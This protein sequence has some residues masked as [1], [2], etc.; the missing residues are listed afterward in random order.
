[1]RIIL[2]HCCKTLPRSS[3]YYSCETFKVIKY[4]LSIFLLYHIILSKQ[5]KW[6]FD[7]ESKTYL[8]NSDTAEFFSNKKYDSYK[9]R[10]CTELCEAFT[11]LMD[12]IYVQFDGMVY[13]Q[14]VG[15]SI[16]T[17]CAPLIVD[18]FYIVTREILCQ[19]S[20]FQRLDLINKFNDTDDIF[21]IDN[22]KFAEHFLSGDVLR[23][24]SYG[25]YISQLVRL[26][27]CCTSVLISIPKFFKS[28]Q[29][30]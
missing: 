20:K 5:K 8:C 6:Y 23:I 14:I 22:L 9:C 10:T 17:N 29:N 7:R 16:G 2:V 19:T 18:L 11:F 28:L 1:M 21:T 25:F 13:K 27:R 3:N 26:A 15:I 4:L 12:N 24:P 30:Y